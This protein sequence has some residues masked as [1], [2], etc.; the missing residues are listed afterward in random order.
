MA[1]MRGKWVAWL[2]VLSLLILAGCNDEPDRPLPVVTTAAPTTPISTMTAPEAVPVTPSLGLETAEPDTAVP[3][4]PGPLATSLAERSSS[5]PTV[6]HPPT[7]TPVYSAADLQATVLARSLDPFTT[8][9]ING[10]RAFLGYGERLVILDISDPAQPELLGE[11]ALQH[12]VKR[13]Q[14][15]GNTVYLV[16]EISG[17]D[18]TEIIVQTADITDLSN[19]ESL[20][21]YHPGA[22]SVDAIV[23]DGL[24]H[25]FGRQTKWLVVDV[26]NPAVF[27]ELRPVAQGQYLGCTQ[28]GSNISGVQPG[29]GYLYVFGANCRFFNRIAHIFDISDPFN[30]VE[31]GVIAVSDGLANRGEDVIFVFVSSFLRAVDISDR[32]RASILSDLYFNESGVS[33][34]SGKIG[35]IGPYVYLASSDGLSVVEAEEPAAMTLIYRAYE[36]VYFSAIEA[37]GGYVY[38]L[39]WADGLIILDSSDPENPVEVGRWQP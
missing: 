18:S 25:V 7:R 26:S 33:L 2:G 30:P 28:S 6:T 16:L 11:L 27:I 36:G 10:Q 24:L 35:L 5:W 12:R 29:T 13:I 32:Y 19:P 39:D 22:G 4:T 23:V 20:Y 1:A 37:A 34:Q 8:F 21:S 15:V 3:S 17:S 31:H 9:L 14:V 38:L